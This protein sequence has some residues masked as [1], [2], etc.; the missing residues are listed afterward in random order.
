MNVSVRTELKQ[1]KT[2]KPVLMDHF[3]FSRVYMKYF[4]NIQFLFRQILSLGGEVQFFER[5]CGVSPLSLCVSVARHQIERNH[6]RRLPRPS[7]L[8]LHTTGKTGGGKNSTGVINEPLGQSHNS[9]RSEHYLNLKVCF[10]RQDLEKIWR[11]TDWQ[12]TRLK[13]IITCGHDCWSAE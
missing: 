12:A 1:N 6:S 10:Q 3:E 7:A 9:A 13:I 8:R 4:I 11:M 5:T 2:S